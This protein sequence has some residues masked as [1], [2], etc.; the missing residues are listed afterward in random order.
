[1]G[2]TQLN[3]EGK[4][5]VEVAIIRLREFEPSEGYYLANSGGKD[6][7]VTQD[8]AE[9]SKVQFDAHYNV[10]PIDPPEIYTFL[11]EYY[12]QVS[13]DIH[14]KNFWKRF[15]TEG[16]PMR[17]MRWCCEIIKEKR[18][19]GRTVATGIRWS[20][21]YRRRKRRRSTCALRRQ[22]RPPETRKRARLCVSPRTDRGYQN[23]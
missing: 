20:E 9:L 6:S 5:K 2:I 22:D 3:F 15:M 18:G 7:V 11:K 12:P 16:P 4:N 21:S 17:H 13:W 23:T 1:M 8:L 14:A 19:D 10:S